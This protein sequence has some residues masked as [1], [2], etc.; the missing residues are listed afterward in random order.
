MIVQFFKGRTS[1]LYVSDSSGLNC[2]TFGEN[3][4]PLSLHQTRYLFTDALFCFEVRM[5]QRIV[6]S[7]SEA[8]FHTFWPPVEIRG[9]ER[10][11]WVG[12]SSLPMAEPVIR[13]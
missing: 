5:T 7:K 13:I 12:W 6:V 10:E 9:G 3:W 4:V 8:K 11:I 1:K 2:T